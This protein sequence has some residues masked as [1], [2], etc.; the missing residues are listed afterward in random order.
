MSDPATYII[1]FEELNPAVDLTVDGPV[2]ISFA[3]DSGIQIINA[4]TYDG[5][6][7]VSP[8]AFDPTVLPTKNKTMVDDLTVTQVPYYETHSDTG[9]TIYIAS[10]A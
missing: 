7:T 1:G 5:D 2:T 9:T 6:Y 3:L 10:E 4:D 8:K